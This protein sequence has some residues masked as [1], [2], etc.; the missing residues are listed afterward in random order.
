MCPT[1]IDDFEAVDDDVLGEGMRRAAALGLPV[2]VHAERP[3]RLGAPGPTW[4]EWAASRPPVAELEAIDRALALAEETGCSLHVVHVSTG[5]GVVHVAEARARGV[6]ATCET[7][8]HYLALA[9]EDMERLGTLAKCAPPLRPEA[10]RHALWRHLTAG[11]VAFVGSDHSPCPPEMKAGGFD[12]AWGG[13]AG[14]QTTLAVLLTEGHGAG[15]LALG[16]GGGQIVGA[17]ARLRLPKGRL[18]P[19][20]D[21]DL[22]LV[23]LGAT[24]TLEQL[25]DRHQANP[26]RGRELRG[27]VVRTLL[28]G[29]TVFHD[30]RVAPGAH[31]RLLKPQEAT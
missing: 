21:A 27:R 1:G 12:S 24:Y 10:E 26:F 13:I 11:D 31:G 18:E 5:A 3:D 19:G 7:C 4:R 17:A 29:Q 8:P 22:A 14:A 9:D 6:D 28:R 30:G 25:F 23:D 2:G 20:A 15:R 16:M